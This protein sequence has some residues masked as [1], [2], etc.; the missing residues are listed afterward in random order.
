MENL[1]AKRLDLLT[2]EV[3]L[4]ARLMRSIDVLIDD[5]QTVRRRYTQ[6]L[7]DIRVEMESLPG[8]NGLGLG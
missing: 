8:S 4:I 1:T 2:R 6:E 5:L 3:A 7:T